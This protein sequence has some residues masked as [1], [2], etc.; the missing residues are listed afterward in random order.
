M[1][2]RLGDLLLRHWPCSGRWGPCNGFASPEL[3]V[4]IRYK[5]QKSRDRGGCVGGYVNTEV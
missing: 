1:K 3:D 2:L 4:S 5:K